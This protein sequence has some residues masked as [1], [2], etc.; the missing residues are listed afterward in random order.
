MKKRTGTTC[1]I[2]YSLDIWGDPWSL[3]I[4]R[5][6]LV[7]NKRYYRE[8]LASSEHIAT[9]ILTTRLQSLVE[10][11]LIVR[12]KGKTNRSQTTYQPTQKA[13]D[14]LP[15]IL[16]VMQWGIKYNPNIE[17][18]PLMQQVKEEPQELHQYLLKRF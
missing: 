10:A 3:V 16:S 13:I 1:P 12:I 2:V 7:G 4:L 15:A 17:M 5:D 9:N 11:E 18:N 6:I 14:L 8:L